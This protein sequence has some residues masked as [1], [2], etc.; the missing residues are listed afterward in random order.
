MEGSGT[1]RLEKVA[2]EVTYRRLKQTLKDLEG[3]PSPGEGLRRIAFEGLEPRLS[4]K[5]YDNLQPT[6]Y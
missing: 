5:A 2:N 1:V 3:Q 6:R 4:S